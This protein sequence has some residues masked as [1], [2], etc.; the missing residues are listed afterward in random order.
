M[1][2]VFAILIFLITYGFSQCIEQPYQI[3]AFED[4]F[5]YTFGTYE[6]IYAYSLMRGEGDKY[7]I[8]NDLLHFLIDYSTEYNLTLEGLDSLY[9]KYTKE[10]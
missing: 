2:K 4:G 9:N 1:K 5:I 7:I 3:R 6:P 10:Q 8:G